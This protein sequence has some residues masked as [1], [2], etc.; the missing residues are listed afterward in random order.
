MTT[1][2]TALGLAPII[3]ARDVLFYDLALV[4][5]GGLLIG[6]MLTLIVIPCLYGIVFGVGAIKRPDMQTEDRATGLL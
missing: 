6:T 5:A 3:I 4:I 2:T 1:C